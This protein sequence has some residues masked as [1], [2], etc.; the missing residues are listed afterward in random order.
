MKKAAKPP[1]RRKPKPRFQLDPRQGGLASAAAKRKDRDQQIR[2]QV[3]QF[4][5]VSTLSDLRWRPL[6]G[7]LARV[8][9]LADRAY[10]HLK[11]R[12]SLLTEDGELCPSIDVFRRLAETQSSLLKLAGLT[13]TAKL[14]EQPDYEAA[15][16][17]IE[18]MKRTRGGDI[19]NGA[20]SSES[21]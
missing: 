15:F 13:P 9:I 21:G 11:D 17:R 20:E 14:S 12:K 7:A 19:D 18:A 10:R 4:V 6:L 16:Q 5:K 8:T 3:Q 2:R 1:T